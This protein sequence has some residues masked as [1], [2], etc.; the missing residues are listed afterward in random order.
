MEKSDLKFKPAKFL[1][2]QRSQ[3]WIETAI[4][5]LIGLTLI[6]ITLS[7]ATPQINKIR[8]KGIIDQTSFVLSEMN[9]EILKVSEVAGNVRIINFKILKGKLEINSDENKITY[10]LENTDVKIS[11]PNKPNLPNTIVVKE[12]DL[13]FKTFES[14][15]KYNIHLELNYNDILDLTYDNSEQTKL[16]HGGGTTY[17][18]KIENVGDN[19]VGENVHIDVSI[20]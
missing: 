18:I 11:E 13:A 2:L 15:K 6:A 12:G 8:E 16:F 1:E 14:G 19:V 7:I 4:Y 17:K 9:K 5:T 10:I 20:I 3:I